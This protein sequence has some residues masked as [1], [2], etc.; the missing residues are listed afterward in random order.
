MPQVLDCIE[1]LARSRIK[2]LDEGREEICP[3]EQCRLG[4]L[5]IQRACAKSNMLLLF[6]RTLSA[7]AY[8]SSGCPIDAGGAKGHLDQARK[9]HDMG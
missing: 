8:L 2:T 6:G 3:V 7:T 1:H 4:D 5:Q 9:L